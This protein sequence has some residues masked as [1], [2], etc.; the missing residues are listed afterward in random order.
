VPSKYQDVVEIKT[1]LSP[2]NRKKLSR[3]E[4]KET[5]RVTKWR[6]VVEHYNRRLQEFKFLRDRVPNAV[7]PNL[8]PFI[9]AVAVLQQLWRK[10]LRN[11]DVKSN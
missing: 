5:R 2:A 9:R 11:F 3:E 4:W 6:N 7:I 1:P 10:P 8:M